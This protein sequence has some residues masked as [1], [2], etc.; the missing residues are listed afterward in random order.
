M[1]IEKF[2]MEECRDAKIVK[3]TVSIVS[4]AIEAS[5]QKSPKAAA[6][7]YFHRNK[8][9][10]YLCEGDNLKIILADYD[11]IQISSAISC[12]T[13]LLRDKQMIFELICILN[14]DRSKFGIA[15]VEYFSVSNYR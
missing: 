2:V 1:N 12:V 6:F 13:E 8:N 5:V 3:K 11:D 15:L 4:N 7:V 9:L 10:L 14:E